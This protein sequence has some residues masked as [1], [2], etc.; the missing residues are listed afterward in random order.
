MI[1]ISFNENT[2]ANQIQRLLKYKY[3]I[4]FLYKINKKSRFTTNLL[5]KNADFYELVCVF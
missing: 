3:I 5:I 1:R 2:Q 4:I